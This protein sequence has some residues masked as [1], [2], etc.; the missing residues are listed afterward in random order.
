[1]PHEFFAKHPKLQKHFQ[2]T[3]AFHAH[4]TE[5]K[6]ALTT[7][8]MET[9]N[10]DSTFDVVQLISANDQLAPHPK[11]DKYALQNAMNEMGKLDLELLGIMLTY[12]SYE[13]A[14]NDLKNKDSEFY[15]KLWPIALKIENKARLKIKVPETTLEKFK[16]LGRVNIHL[17]TMIDNNYKDYFNAKA[18]L[19][20]A[21]QANIIHLAKMMLSAQKNL[22]HINLFGDL[23]MKRCNGNKPFRK[24]M[25][26]QPLN[27]DEINTLHDT[28]GGIKRIPTFDEYLKSLGNKK[29]DKENTNITYLYAQFIQWL[30]DN[31]QDEVPVHHLL[32]NIR[33]I[34]M[35]VTHVLVGKAYASIDI[36]IDIHYMQNQAFFDG[37]VKTYINTRDLAKHTRMSNEAFIGLLLLGGLSAVLI[38]SGFLPDFNTSVAIT[39]WAIGAAFGVAFSALGVTSLV[40]R[41]DSAALDTAVYNINSILFKSPD[42]DEKK[43][44]QATLSATTNTLILSRGVFDSQGTFVNALKDYTPYEVNLRKICPSLK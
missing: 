18:K 40:K 38:G 10:S 14:Q 7:F 17:T 6:A 4:A 8:L 24:L 9:K 12:E 31:H 29:F 37:E 26:N 1:M 42:L 41:Q 36:D 27:A 22:K 5:I 13:A 33:V 20:A 35:Y 21:E 30:I 15:K 11:D 16:G 34:S 44:I 39:L 32:Y 3:D 2:S 23:L 25:D 28:L 19:A 43:A